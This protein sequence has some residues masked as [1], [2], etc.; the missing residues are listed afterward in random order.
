MSTT[1][2]EFLQTHAPD[3]VLH[4]EHADQLLALYDGDAGAQVT[5]VPE[6]AP[7]DAAE[8]MAES[9]EQGVKPEPEAAPAG[10]TASET[11]SASAAILAEAR[12]GEQHWKVQH[13]AV[14]QELQALKAQPQPRADAGPAPTAADNQAAVAE[15]AIKAGVDPALFGDFSEESIAK[16]ID[17][18]VELRAKGL[19]QQL[20]Q[21][22]AAKV[23]AMVSQALAPI[24]AKEAQ[25]SNLSHYDAI[26]EAHPDAAS[27][28]Q[29]K[30]L[31]DW[32]ESQPSFARAG[33]SQALAAGTT[34]QVIELF[35]EFKK[36]T[37]APQTAAAAVG[38]AQADPKAAAQAVIAKAKPQVPVSLSAFPGAAAGPANA[39]ETVAS[40][41]PA[42][43]LEALEGMT[44]SQR[45]AY[46]SR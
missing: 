15:A 44:E 16:G 45:E 8:T 32:I 22:V 46:L 43:M 29:S 3:G 39:F 23:E 28:A 26:H 5:A 18:L 30:E 19:E 11:D 9:A 17:Q 24:Q 25:A 31:T 42:A 34:E 4:P 7:G 40:L 37:G 10:A 41:S 1:P 14:A 27:I 6:S 35:T 38:A 36:A 21:R 13:D 20:D 12:A 33:Y 2:Q